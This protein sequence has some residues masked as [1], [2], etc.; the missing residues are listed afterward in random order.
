[1][2]SDVKTAMLTASPFLR[3]DTQSMYMDQESSNAKFRL[4]ACIA[5]SRISCSTCYSGYTLRVL[6]QNTNTGGQ[7]SSVTFGVFAKLRLRHSFL[8]GF[9]GCA[10]RVHARL[11]QGLFPRC[12]QRLAVHPV[13]KAHSFF[14]SNVSAVFDYATMLQRTCMAGTAL[15]A[16]RCTIASSVRRVEP[17]STCIFDS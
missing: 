8:C 10:R 6:D 17:A 1:M 3:P 9:F 15:T 13:W 12:P 4:R 5:G 14:A 7:P 16:T 2:G 11:P